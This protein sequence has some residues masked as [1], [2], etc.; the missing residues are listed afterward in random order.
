VQQR[1]PSIR[2]P[3]AFSLHWIEGEWSALIA[4]A[5]RSADA[6]LSIERVMPKT[7]LNELPVVEVFGHCGEAAAAECTRCQYGRSYTSDSLHAD[8]ELL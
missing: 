5:C 7:L 8:N 2:T 4:A 3:P 6:E 1:P